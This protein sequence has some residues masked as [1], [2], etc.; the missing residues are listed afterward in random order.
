MWPVEHMSNAYDAR[1]VSIKGGVDRKWWIR[2]KAKIDTGAKRCSI[3]ESL[4]TALELPVVGHVKVRN[5]MGSQERPV[6]AA[7]IRIGHH[8]YDVELTVA[9][10][11]Q[12]ICPMLLGKSILDEI[13]KPRLKPSDHSNVPQFV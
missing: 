11:S 10:R 7:K 6:V 4:A 9:D 3:D 1:W 2:A 13:G 5:A 12:M 8:T